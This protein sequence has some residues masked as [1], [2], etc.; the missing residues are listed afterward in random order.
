M[1]HNDQNPTITTIDITPSTDGYKAIRDRLVAQV[2]DD[3]KKARH[4]AD[5]E[6]LRSIVEISEYLG[7]VHARQ[8]GV[9]L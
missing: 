1:T 8:G 5:V 6:I 9:T 2:L 4:D 3:V 7:A